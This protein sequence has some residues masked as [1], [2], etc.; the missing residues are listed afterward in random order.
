MTTPPEFRKR[1]DAARSRSWSGRLLIGGIAV[2]VIAAAVV[3][4]PR[5]VKRFSAAERNKFAHLLTDIAFRGPFL[6][7]V[8][9]QGNLDSQQNV[10]VSSSVEGTTTIISIVPEGTWV[11]K[12]EIVCELDSSLMS[13][14]AQKQQI[15][16]TNAVSAELQAKELLDVQ[17]LQNE[18]DIATA[19]NLWD[20]AVLDK[21]K[22]EKGEF[23][24]LQNELKGNVEIA[25]EEA[26]QAKERHEFNKQ[27]VKKGFIN[28]NELETSRIQMEKSNF[29]VAKAKKELQVLE[30]FDQ[31]RTMAEL[32]ANELELG[33][34]L[35]RVKL[36]AESAQKQ[37][38]QAYEA[39]QKSAAL[40]KS[41]LERLERQI[42]NC[43]LRAPQS[44]EVVY[45]N[46]S[47]SR[48]SRGGSEGPAIEVGATVEERQAI[49]NLPDVS[50]MKVDARVHESLI[51]NVRPGL[52]AKIQ[53]AGK[54]DVIYRGAVGH[55]SSV[56]T[57][58]S[59]PNYDLREYPVSINITDSEEKVKELKPG[60]TA[61]VE[62]FVDSRNDVLQVPVQSVVGI[63]GS[64]YAF[65]LTRDG[66]ERRELK[67]GQANDT[68][69]E[70]LDGVAEG[71]KVILNPRT[72]FATEIAE[73]TGQ[74]ASRSTE[75]DAG[76]NQTDD[77]PTGPAGLRPGRPGPG[78]GPPLAGGGSPGGLG[79]ERP[80]GGG[81]GN[82]SQMFSTMDADRDGK[83]SGDEIPVPMRD[84]VASM[85]TDG[86]GA[87]SQAEI[88]VAMER[89]RQ[90]GGGPPGGGAARD[91]ATGGGG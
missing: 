52:P 69:V 67:I 86:D 9:I 43:K 74:L 55:V 70:I 49:F 62:V 31:R 66:P 76:E 46:L 47:S 16:V 58:G 35:E 39:A 63:V 51:A 4:G 37:A 33:R 8:S 1:L 65:V 78:L 64:Y 14:N 48:R 81:L 7:T 89:F 42:A 20:L 61:Q 79:G 85:D 22:Y 91:A 80:R 18:S 60:L 27:Q 72:N 53:I 56:P 5:L 75:K 17:K 73:L 6:L 11:E 71:E 34:E 28:Q 21:E 30:E 83:L 12:G 59:W 45:A 57:T 44:G 40:E 15:V 41:I 87:I 19:R 23:S 77:V 54:H 68:A 38:E 25:L 3:G 10:T 90:G 36:K 26:I 50:K 2:G 24:K 32:T 13:D 82:L 29:A 88:N 84:R